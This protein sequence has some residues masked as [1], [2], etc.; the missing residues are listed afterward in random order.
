LAEI[1]E[2][3]QKL[4]LEQKKQLASMLLSDEGLTSFFKDK[5]SSPQNPKNLAE[6]SKNDLIGSPLDVEG[7]TASPT[8][9][10]TGS[11]NNSIGSPLNVEGD[12]ASPP[13]TP[14]GSPLNVEGDTASPTG[15]PDVPPEAQTEPKWGFL[16]VPSKRWNKKF[17]KAE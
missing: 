15:S 6:E 17:S 9:S 7:D 8:G 16:H 4:S 3:T 10:P 12:T 2:K 14:I 11:P 13:V 1:L 5:T